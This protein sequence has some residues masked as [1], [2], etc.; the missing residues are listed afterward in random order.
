MAVHP[1]GHMGLNNCFQELI[2]FQFDCIPVDTHPNA[3]Q[4]LQS[5]ETEMGPIKKRGKSSEQSKEKIYSVERIVNKRY[6]NFLFSSETNLAIWFTELH[7]VV[8]PNKFGCQSTMGL[9]SVSTRATLVFPVLLSILP[10]YP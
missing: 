1:H 10:K 4:S 3:F 2:H 5:G 6:D 9:C 7:R 8:F